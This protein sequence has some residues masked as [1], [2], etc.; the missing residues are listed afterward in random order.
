MGAVFVEHSRQLLAGGA[1]LDSLGE[2]GVAGGMG[3][4][5]RSTG[6]CRRQWARE[7]G[8]RTGAGRVERTLLLLDKAAERTPGALGPVIQG[9]AA[10][11]TRAWALGRGT[12][13]MPTTQVRQ[14]CLKLR[15][16]ACVS[17]NKQCHTN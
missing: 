8:R 15:W 13:S 10:G 12:P 7:G 1:Q 11:E 2:Q 6:Q 9:L 3:R 5:R 17:W 4:S 16:P 14:G